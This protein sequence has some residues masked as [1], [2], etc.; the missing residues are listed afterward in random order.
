MDDG[1]DVKSS[2]SSKKENK[3]KKRRTET[4]ADADDVVV[5]KLSVPSEKIVPSDELSVKLESCAE[6]GN[7]IAPVVGYF[8]SG[9]DP[10]K[11]RKHKGEEGG[12]GSDTKIRVFRNAR[13]SNRL[14]VVVSPE[15]SKVEYIGNSYLGEAAAP[16]VCTYALGVLDKETQTLKIVPISANKIIRLEPRVKVPQVLD[17]EDHT[18]EKKASRADL[19]NMF[20]TKDAKRRARKWDALRQ[21]EVDPDALR[22]LESKIN[23]VEINKEAIEVIDIHVGNIPPHDMTAT[24]PEEAYPLKKIILKGEWDHLSDVMEV[25][26]SCSNAT[27][28]VEILQ[29]NDY[30]T[31]VCNRVL[32]LF[33]IKD[34]PQ[35]KKLACIF[36][37]IT[38]LLRF[39]NL[40]KHLKKP[41]GVTSAMYHNI[42]TALFQ[43]FVKLFAGSTGERESKDESNL[44][45]SYILVLTLH[46]DGFTINISDI[47]K[48]L[49]MAPVYLKPHFLHLGCKSAGTNNASEVALN[50][51]LQFQQLKLP[52]RR[53]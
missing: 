19:T 22:E 43:R 38:Y 20:G 37:Y 2:S 29:N 47:A 17:E 49:K 16:Q 40:P 7:K 27:S 4:N 26:Q 53:R 14:Q 15:Q 45:I 8:P 28:A 6:S 51:P 10:L 12:G 9:F 48:D 5:E 23:T 44:L 50:V 34:E 42:P 52:T 25:M 32:K 41:I 24:T 30:G 33:M 35:K 36:S 39:R 46:A 31:F 3:R 13:F 18:I 21:K 1:G 11:Q